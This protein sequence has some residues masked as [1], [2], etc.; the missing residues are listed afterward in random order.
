MNNYKGT[1]NNKNDNKYYPVLFNKPTAKNQV[2]FAS[3]SKSGLVAFSSACVNDIG[4]NDLAFSHIL[5]G[6]DPNRQMI[7]LKLLVNPTRGSTKIMR[8][9]KVVRLHSSSFFHLNNLNLSRLKGRYHVKRIECPDDP[10][11]KWL[12]IDISNP[13][14]DTMQVKSE[15][16]H[17]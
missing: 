5:W 17:S 8:I 10:H 1:Q 2:R 12:G 13:F 15:A 4:L 9:N 6:Y 11:G 3:I 14:K 16:Y 7:C